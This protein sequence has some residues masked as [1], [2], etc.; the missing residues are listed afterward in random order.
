M[1]ISEID[2]RFG[3]VIESDDGNLIV[4]FQIIDEFGRRFLGGIHIRTH[5]AATGIEDEGNIYWVIRC[6][7]VA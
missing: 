3:L 7:Q 1:I 6:N 4:P 2:T 5:H